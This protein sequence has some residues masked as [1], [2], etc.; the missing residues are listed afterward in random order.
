MDEKK[1]KK[2]LADLAHGHHHPDEHDW[3]EGTIEISDKASK[4]APDE[5]GSIVEPARGKKNT[6]A[7]KTQAGKTTRTGK[8][9]AAKAK[10]PKTGASKTRATRARK[11]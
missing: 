10:A 2:H 3:G 7:K 8:S 9:K 1:F 4:V 11:R 5:A 6:A